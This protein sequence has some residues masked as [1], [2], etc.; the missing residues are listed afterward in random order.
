MNLLDLKKD[1]FVVL[2]VLMESFGAMIFMSGLFSNSCG[3]AIN[4]LIPKEYKTPC[5]TELT[6][7]CK[8][9]KYFDNLGW[10]IM[11]LGASIMAGAINGRDKYN[12]ENR[13]KHLQ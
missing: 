2:L 1:C 13:I 10:L 3:I 7:S 6:Y 8:L 4:G 5:S 11:L 12:R 9:E